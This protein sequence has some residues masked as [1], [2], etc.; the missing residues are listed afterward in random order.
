MDD[1]E[2]Y[3]LA[4]SKADKGEVRVETYPKLPRG[5]HTVL[6]KTATLE[7]NEDTSRSLTLVGQVM[8]SSPENGEQFQVR[9]NLTYKD[10]KKNE[11]GLAVAAGLIQ[12]AKAAGT[13]ISYN[14]VLSDPVKGVA[15]LD[16]ETYLKNG[17]VRQNQVIHWGEKEPPKAAPPKQAEAAPASSMP[18]VDAPF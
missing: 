9:I 15:W 8:D 3:K 10:G 16:L 12:A 14:F 1:Q 7:K 4:A 13:S 11:R 18:H 2:L 6:I 17:E 5:L